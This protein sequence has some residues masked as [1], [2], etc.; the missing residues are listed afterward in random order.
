M[1]KKIIFNVMNIL[2]QEATRL[3]KSDD[4]RDSGGEKKSAVFPKFDFFKSHVYV[5]KQTY[6]ISSN[7]TN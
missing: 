2:A 4:W 7:F 1:Q 3:N 5:L 6:F